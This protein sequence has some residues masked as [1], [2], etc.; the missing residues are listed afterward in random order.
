MTWNLVFILIVVPK[1][2]NVN[3]QTMFLK[4]FLNSSRY[5]FTMLSLLSLSLSL[6]LSFTIFSKELITK[7]SIRNGTKKR[8]YCK[9]VVATRWSCPMS[10]CFEIR[11][12]A[13]NRVTVLGRFI[14]P[15]NSQSTSERNVSNENTPAHAALSM[16][17]YYIFSSLTSPYV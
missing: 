7:R 1:I 3:S 16:P 8:N 9:H 15:R 12:I 13:Y 10:E 2:V 14:E 17:I 4:D 6:S 5:I 11:M